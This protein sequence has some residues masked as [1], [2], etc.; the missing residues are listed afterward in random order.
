M[1]KKKHKE[2]VKD[3]SRTW[4]NC[5]NGKRWRAR[6]LE[7]GLTEGSRALVECT[8]VTEQGVI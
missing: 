8:R 6:A 2:S 7:Q 4:D 5:A 3:Q 1:I